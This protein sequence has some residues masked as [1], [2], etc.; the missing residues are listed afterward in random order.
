VERLRSAGKIVFFFS[1]SSSSSFFE[2][3][4]FYPQVVSL[5]DCLNAHYGEK[6]FCATEQAGVDQAIIAD[7]RQ[8]RLNETN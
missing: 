4:S 5:F 1:S 7:I 8:K 2:Q 3:E 6:S